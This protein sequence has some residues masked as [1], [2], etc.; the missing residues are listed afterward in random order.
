MEHMARTWQGQ[1][2][3][4]IA[5]PFNYTGV[6]QDEKFLIPKIVSHFRRHAAFIE[7]GNLDVSRDFSDVRDV[8]AAYVAMLLDAHGVEGQ[9]FNVCSGR[10]HSLREVLGMAE[11][12]CGHSIEIRVNPE[13]VRA[14]EV[15]RL[16]GSGKKL[17]QYIDRPSLRTLEQTLEWMLSGESS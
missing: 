3:I 4:V 14:N 12:I 9:T 15:P 5:R 16:L 17:H 2:P 8:V 13:F 7:L 6:G 10:A 1:L 11:R